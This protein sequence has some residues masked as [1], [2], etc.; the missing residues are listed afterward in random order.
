MI[1]SMNE[2]Q[3]ALSNMLRASDSRL[4]FISLAVKLLV[5]LQVES[6]RTT[7]TWITVY[8]QVRRR[9]N[10]SWRAKKKSSRIIFQ[11][12]SDGECT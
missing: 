1:S 2:H 7:I 4:S 8:Y 6:I 10:R 9:K 3:Q 5:F 12:R 11:G